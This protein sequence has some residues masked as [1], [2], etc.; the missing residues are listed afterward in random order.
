M[1]RFAFALI[2]TYI[3]VSCGEPYRN[4]DYTTMPF[5]T[6]NI[7][8]L[9]FDLIEKEALYDLFLVCRVDKKAMKEIG[10]SVFFN[11]DMISPDSLI[12]RKQVALP[13]VN[14]SISDIIT[15]KKF[16]AC[17]DYK[18]H[19]AKDIKTGQPGRWQ[20]MISTK[21]PEEKRNVVLGFG[22]SINPIKSN[23]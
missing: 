22:M 2:S 19:Y 15:V 6:T 16:G 21:L 11:I 7:M 3:L 14:K 23:E 9:E 1:K 8:T 10:D 12:V 13:L 20:F 17:I 4:Y 18:W 5:K